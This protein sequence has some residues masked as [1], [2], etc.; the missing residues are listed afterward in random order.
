MADEF[1]AEDI[2]K[3]AAGRSAAEIARQLLREGHAHSV[4]SAQKSTFSSDRVYVRCS[5]EKD[6]R[7]FRHDPGYKR[8]KLL[9]TH[10]SLPA[11][12][13]AQP[14]PLRTAEPHPLKLQPA[15]VFPG[16]SPENLMQSIAT[17]L[18]A[19][20]RI[21]TKEREFLENVRKR[22]GISEEI[23]KASLAAAEK[24]AAK[25]RLPHDQKGRTVLLTALIAAAAAD[26][27]V[28]ASEWRMLQ[29]VA[30]KMGVSD[31]GLHASIEK[32]LK[33]HSL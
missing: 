14:P 9:A 25:I 17:I 16:V 6:A 30:R 20:G 21:S 4:Y 8:T 10:E 18:G 7:E 5:T 27:N 26:G 2:E 29:A 1:L 15:E 23:A 22:F 32:Y 28:P 3:R 31:T 11:K 33:R 24:R 19:D 13:T 12:P